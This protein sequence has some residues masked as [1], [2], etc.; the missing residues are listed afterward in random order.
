MLLLPFSP[1][2]KPN[3]ELAAAKP[4]EDGCSSHHPLCI[5]SVFIHKALATSGLLVE[6]LFAAGSLLAFVGGKLVEEALGS[7]LVKKLL[8]M[9]GFLLL[10]SSFLIDKALAGCCLLA[11]AL[12]LPQFVQGPLPV[13]VVGLLASATSGKNRPP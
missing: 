13:L 7:M 6:K 2:G 11:M 4:K 8:T 10:M 12:V 3:M 9:C 5:G 1:L